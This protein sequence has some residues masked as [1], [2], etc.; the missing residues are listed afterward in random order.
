LRYADALIA[1]GLAAAAL[2]ELKLV[3]GIEGIE[4]IEGSEGIDRAGIAGAGS[5]RHLAT[6]VL[7]AGNGTDHARKDYARAAST[8]EDLG[9]GFS[10]RLLARDLGAADNLTQRA[11]R[12]KD[13]WFARTPTF[14]LTYRE[15]GRADDEAARRGLA[16]LGMMLWHRL[17]QSVRREPWARIARVD[18]ESYLSTDVTEVLE[19]LDE[20]DETFKGPEVASRLFALRVALLVRRNDER[21]LTLL[22]GLATPLDDARKTPLLTNLLGCD[23]YAWCL[24]ATDRLVTL[25]ADDPANRLH[26]QLQRARLLATAGQVDDVYYLARTLVDE[27]PASGDVWQL[28]A[29]AARDVGRPGDAD[30]AYARIINSV[31]TGSDAWRDAQLERLQLRLQAGE[32]ADACALRAA[33]AVDARTE[34]A[35]IKA[36]KTRGIPCRS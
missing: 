8:A 35:V 27:F 25:F 20:L 2:T 29:G 5:L 36:L 9:A 21:L 19:A 28:Y 24:A 4:G 6:A 11:T 22:A 13:P 26:L 14:E 31:P 23:G 30:L 17:D 34:A 32:E 3:E 12:A 16:Q 1:S 15:V 7:Y 33:V 18:L 10:R